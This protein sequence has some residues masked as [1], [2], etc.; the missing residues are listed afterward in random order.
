MGQMLMSIVKT[1]SLNMLR[2]TNSCEKQAF[3]W[4]LRAVYLKMYKQQ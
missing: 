3:L 4:L 1:V 2:G